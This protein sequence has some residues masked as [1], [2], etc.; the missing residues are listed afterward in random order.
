MAENFLTSATVLDDATG[1]FSFPIELERLF[2][3]LCAEGGDLKKAEQE[4][5]PVSGV[6]EI[7]EESRGS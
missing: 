7:T 3:L 4:H 6:S 1:S 2:Y 5:P